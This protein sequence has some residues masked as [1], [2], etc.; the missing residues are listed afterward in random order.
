MIADYLIIDDSMLET[1]QALDDSER[2]DV[3]IG[4]LESGQY[5]HC[6]MGKLW[7]VMHFVLTGQSATNPVADA[8]LSEAIIGLETFSDDEDAD[9]IAYNDWA[10]LGE[11]VHAFEQI[12]FGKKMEN[13]QMKALRETRLFPEVIW[14]DKKSNLGKELTASFNELKDLYSQALDTGNHVLISIL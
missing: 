7:D 13:L 5:P 10:M 2:A 6:D 4:W 8:P 3:V 11:I 14:Q 9:F 1:L 12:N